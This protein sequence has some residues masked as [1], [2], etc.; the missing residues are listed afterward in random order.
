MFVDHLVLLRVSLFFLPPLP[1]LA[2]PTRVPAS[3]D[4]S[5]Y[6]YDLHRLVPS[7]VMDPYTFGGKYR[8]EEE[9]AI[10]GCGQ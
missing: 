1:S 5:T 2:T 6:N 9:I 4:A 10:G 3:H 7:D 8:L